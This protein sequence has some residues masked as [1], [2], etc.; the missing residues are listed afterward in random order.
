[1]N[2]IAQ[3][4]DQGEKGFKDSVGGDGGGEHRQLQLRPSVAENVQSVTF[5]GADRNARAGSNRIRESETGV[6]VRTEV[7]R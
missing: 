7:I 3:G 5:A 4:R 2:F 6:T 1:M